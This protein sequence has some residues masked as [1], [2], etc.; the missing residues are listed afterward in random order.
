MLQQYVNAS[1][2]SLSLMTT[3]YHPVRNDMVERFHS[4]LKVA[5]KVDNDWVYHI[6]LILLA[7]R[8]TIKED[9][10]ATPDQLVCGETLKL[11]GE[12]FHPV[13]AT[14]DTDFV[15]NLH[16]RKKLLLGLSRKSVG[17]TIEF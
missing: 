15:Q 14:I 2:Q 10:D 13:N 4:Q 3:A 8:A 11:P 7:F 9:L 1:W 5:C 12:F 6:L 17:I 16:F